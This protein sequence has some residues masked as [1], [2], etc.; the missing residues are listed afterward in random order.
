MRFYAVEHISE[1]AQR[2]LSEDINLFLTATLKSDVLHLQELV[3][4]P[5]R[6]PSSDCL[7]VR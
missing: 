1:S 3:R 5:A 2:A 7:R 6:K 4:R